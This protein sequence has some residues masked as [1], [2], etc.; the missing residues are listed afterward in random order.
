MQ[1]HAH[2]L[3]IDRPGF[4]D[5]W[6]QAS[7]SIYIYATGHMFPQT[8]PEL[9]RQ[10]EILSVAMR[11][12]GVDDLFINISEHWVSDGTLTQRLSSLFITCKNLPLKNSEIHKQTIER[13][14]I[15]WLL[16]NEPSVQLSHADST[17]P[18]SIV[19]NICI[20]CRAIISLKHQSQERCF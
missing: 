4:G 6:Q 7:Y 18:G 12:Q 19:A 5:R 2:T 13:T 17:C 14:T 3:T 11:W 20:H 15:F 8:H 9:S 10:I 1:R 16:T